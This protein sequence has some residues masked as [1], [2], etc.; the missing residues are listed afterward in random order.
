MADTI[1]ILTSATN[2]SRALSTAQGQR[3]W[4]VPVDLAALAG[5][6]RRAAHAVLA[7]LRTPVLPLSALLEA[8]VLA[9]LV[10]EHDYFEP[11]PSAT[12]VPFLSQ[13]WHSTLPQPH[14]NPTNASNGGAGHVLR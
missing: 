10:A 8:S 12:E 7:Y 6:S 5:L 3:V 9:K 14:D 2:A 4:H 13:S 1:Q 11:E